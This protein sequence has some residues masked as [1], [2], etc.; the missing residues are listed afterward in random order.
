MLPPIFTHLAMIAG[1]LLAALVIAHMFRQRHSPAATTAWL[2]AI[3]LL[4]YVGVPLYLMLGGRKM[5][6][7]ADSKLEIHLPESDVS[8]PIAVTPIDTLL[9]N[10]GIPGATEKNRLSL[11][12]TG[13]DGFSRLVNLIEEAT[14]SIYITTF[15]LASDEVGRDI[16]GRLARKAEQ[17]VVVKVLLDGVGS[18]YTR[19]KA[20]L[21]LARAGGRVLYFFPVIHLPTRGRTNLRNHRKMVIVDERRVMA[22]GTNIATEYIGPTPDPKRWHDLSFILEG[23]AVRHYTELFRSD[24]E[25]ASGESFQPQNPAPLTLSDPDA[26]AVVQVV[27]S[28]P[29]VAGDPL[30]DAI[31]S[32]IFA[33]KRR[34]WIVTPYFVPDESLCQAMTVAAHRGVDVQILVPEKSNHR[35]ADLARGTYLRDIQQAGGKILLYT[36]GMVHA[37]ILL[38]DDELIMIGSANLDMRSLFLNYETAL[39]AYS[40]SSIQAIERW[41][42]DLAVDTRLGV[43]KVGAFRDL[44]QGVVRMMAPLL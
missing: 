10:Y 18:F 8:V 32:V 43:E 11:C 12:P 23:P 36:R 20:L 19:K 3:V 14:E 30:Y 35:L 29:D 44:C 37:K 25:F 16:I 26:D 15:I 33:A 27:P 24:W 13:E 28:G 40:A 34:L 5:L 17:G 7:V 22:G 38:M 1:F 6:R 2:L 39:F 31:L 9:R 42:T 4:P 21:P 41:I